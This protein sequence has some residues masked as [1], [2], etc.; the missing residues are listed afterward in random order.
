MPVTATDVDDSLSTEE[1]LRLVYMLLR[2][3]AARK[4]AKEFKTLTVDATAL[5]HEAYLCLMRQNSER[6][7]ERTGSNS[8]ANFFAAV[9]ESIRR[10]FEE[11]SR[12]RARIKHGHDWR[13]IVLTDV[14][15]VDED[16]RLLALDD[17]TRSRNR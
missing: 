2:G 9:A 17:A 6:A 15:D 3:L 1:F 11:K 12:R 8:Q 4:L 14:V 5:L 10:I 7:Q 16:A 13:R